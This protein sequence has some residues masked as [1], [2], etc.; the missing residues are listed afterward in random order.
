MAFI[1]GSRRE[2]RTALSAV[3]L[4]VSASLIV[5]LPA[6]ASQRL[7]ERHT[8]AGSATSSLTNVT[9]GYPI[10]IPSMY[11]ILV[12]QQRGYFR[13]AGL[14]VTLANLGSAGAMND[15]LLGGSVQF[16]TTGAYQ[17]VLLETK[18]APGVIIGNP[19]NGTD[20]QLVLS[21]SYMKRKGINSS[22]SIRKVIHALVGARIATASPGATT[23]LEL[24]GL[25]TLYGVSQSAVNFY[26]IQAASAQ[27]LSAK[28]GLVDGY[29]TEPPVSTQGVREGIGSIVIDSYAIPLLTDSPGA[30]YATT[31]TYLAAHPAVVRAFLSAVTQ[32]LTLLTQDP[33]RAAS[34]LLPYVSGLDK[35]ELT[36]DIRSQH[37]TK[38]LAIPRSWL[39]HFVVQTNT[40]HLDPTDITLS[41]VNA[42][43]D[44]AYLPKV[45]PQ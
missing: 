25:L 34:I 30:I 42:S 17:I 8:N 33:K 11:P 20:L 13:H 12:A 15:A 36:K 5:V 27:M 29:W 35:A 9:L 39:Q 7:N 37:F 45:K 10:L 16:I 38:T 22:S 1:P 21:K 19:N 43:Y 26:S 18:G 40:L 4:A 24:K 31:K 44:G 6:L 3:I 28:Q 23:T 2:L 14:N 41:E 32:G